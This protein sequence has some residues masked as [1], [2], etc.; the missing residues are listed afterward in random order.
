L[1]INQPGQYLLGDRAVAAYQP[2]QQ[3]ALY[4]HIPL[5]AST[6]NLPLT[7]TIPP[8]FSPPLAHRNPTTT[9]TLP[10]PNRNRP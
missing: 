8:T 2:L 10:T 6:P 1:A 5:L 7:F 9:S 3:S 4:P